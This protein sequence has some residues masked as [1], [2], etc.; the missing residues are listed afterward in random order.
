M[1]NYILNCQK[2]TFFIYLSVGPPVFTLAHM[3]NNCIKGTAVIVTP[4]S[5]CRHCLNVSLHIFEYTVQ[6]PLC[7][8]LGLLMRCLLKKQYWQGLSEQVLLRIDLLR[9]SAQL[10]QRPVM[11]IS[12]K[13]DE[14]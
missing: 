14:A 11:I 3:S 1:T 10:Y 13:P 6:Q 12:I 9:R 8:Y 7:P 5:H 2:D 4:P